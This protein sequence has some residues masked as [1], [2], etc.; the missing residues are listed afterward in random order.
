[1]NFELVVLNQPFMKFPAGTVFELEAPN[2]LS[3]WDPDERV[4]EK[5][6]FTD[7]RC[8]FLP[9]MGRGRSALLPLWMT[10]PCPPGVF[11][12]VDLHN[13]PCRITGVFSG[14]GDVPEPNGDFAVLR[15]NDVVLQE[16]KQGI[17]VVF[18]ENRQSCL[19]W[20]AH[21]MLTNEQVQENVDVPARPEKVSFDFSGLTPGF[22]AL[23]L[24]YDG[25]FNH[26]IRF[27]KSFP[28]LVQ[29]EPN[30]NWKYTLFPTQY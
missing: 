15:E 21:N 19:G 22:Y 23:R 25:D 16:A 7:K 13:G 27:Y 5:Q 14:R 12:G 9:D 29:F 30:N 6:S 20:Q 28:L 10:Y 18:P 11:D 4:R 3:D 24:C 17:D 1:L 26:L 8:F 2:E